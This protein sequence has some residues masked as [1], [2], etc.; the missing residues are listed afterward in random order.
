MRSS[1]LLVLAASFLAAC[2]TSRTLDLAAPPTLVAELP[3]TV[4]LVRHA[5]TAGST[6]TE[7]DPALSDAGK[8][9]A[10]ALARTLGSAGVTHV[11]CTEFQ[12]TKDTL[13][14]LAAGLELEIAVVPAGD[15]S[16]QADAL[17]ALPPGSVAVVAGHS[18]TIPGLV[19]W[20]G[21]EAQDLVDHPR[22]GGMLRHYEHDRLFV[23][24]LP[25][26]EDGAAKT[27]EL[28]FGPPNP[29]D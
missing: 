25:V 5:E 23:V 24:T 8:V 21:G 18:N 7:R 26:T 3:V 13:A 17:R 19:K 16:V 2:Q 10:E 6:N 4:I 15:G 11:F 9:R 27:I 1:A 14:P 20:L 29:A 12:R 22:F 28:R